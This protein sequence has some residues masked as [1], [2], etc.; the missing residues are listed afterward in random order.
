[1]AAC[2]GDCGCGVI[3]NGYDVAP[4]FKPFR[5]DKFGVPDNFNFGGVEGAALETKF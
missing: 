2:V 1:M 3:I 5:G 4:T